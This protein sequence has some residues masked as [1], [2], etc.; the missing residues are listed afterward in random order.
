MP[1]AIR[2]AQVRRS[3]LAARKPAAGGSRTKARSGESQLPPAPIL[4]TMSSKGQIVIPA[5]LRR[6]YRLA[7]GVTV[8]FREENGQIVLDPDRFAAFRA[9]RGTL[10]AIAEAELMEERRKEREHED[11]ER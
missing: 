10:P 1:V 9:L 11:R 8:A 3:Q 4:A 7:E 2:K 6:K 5:A